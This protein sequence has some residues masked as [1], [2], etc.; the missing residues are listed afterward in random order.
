MLEKVGPAAPHQRLH[1]CGRRLVT[2]EEQRQGERQRLRRLCGHRLGGEP[3]DVAVATRQPVGQRLGVPLLPLG[4]RRPAHRLAECLSP[5]RD[6]CIAHATEESLRNAGDLPFH[7]GQA[8]DSF[9][10]HPGIGVPKG[11]D[12]GTVVRHEG[13]RPCRR[14][15]VARRVRAGERAKDLL[16]TLPTILPHHAGDCRRGPDPAIVVMCRRQELIRRDGFGRRHLEHESPHR[17]VWRCE[18]LRRHGGKGFGRRLGKR[19]SGKLPGLRV[20]AADVAL[21]LDDLVRGRAPD[22][23]L[24]VGEAQRVRAKP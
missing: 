2:G 16:G 3:A 12:H 10:P 1:R 9:Q 23:L 19:R 5:H 4:R 17:R 11:R 20:R 18:Q 6:L 21:Q 7:A 22:G 15:A 14:R 13:G 8:P 24:K